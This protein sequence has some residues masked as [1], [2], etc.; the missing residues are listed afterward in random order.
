MGKSELRKK[1]VGEDENIEGK[2]GVRMPNME[3]GVR[4]Q[5]VEKGNEKKNKVK[6][7]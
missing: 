7:E 6:K 3:K 4:R 2:G 1:N 5:K